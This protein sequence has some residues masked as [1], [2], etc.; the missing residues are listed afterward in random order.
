[1]TEGGASVATGWK[2]LSEIM[3][4]VTLLVMGVAGP[5]GEMVVLGSEIEVL[6]K[7]PLV[8][9]PDGVMLVMTVPLVLGVLL[10]RLGRT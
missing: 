3:P 8:N 6:I 7:G 10:L 1:M 4:A 5:V 9:F 2:I